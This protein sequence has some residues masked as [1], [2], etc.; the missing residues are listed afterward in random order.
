MTRIQRLVLA[1]MLAC[2]PWLAHA[3][4][5]KCKQADGSVSYQDHACPAG[6][7][8]SASVA[9]DLSLDSGMPQL[10]GLDA[11]C[12]QSARHMVSV[13]RGPADA[14]LH[15]CWRARLTSLC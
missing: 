8:S 15:Q 6:T 4:G 13:C 5:Y 9:T 2:A 11:G 14:S 12:R 1:A 7:A 3:Q 10:E